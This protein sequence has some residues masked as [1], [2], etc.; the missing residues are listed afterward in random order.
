LLRESG[1]GQDI[2]EVRGGINCKNRIPLTD[3]NTSS[4]VIDSLCDQAKKKDIAVTGLYCDFLSQQD[5]T[6]ANIMGA[7]LKQLVG[8]GGIPNYVREAFQEAKSEFGGRGLRLADLMG[9]LRT[10]ITSLPRGFICIDALDECLPKHLPELLEC[11]RDIARES[12]ST[13]IF[14]T[15]RPHVG[16]VIHRYFTKAVV[17][18]ISP[19]TDDMRNYVE[20]RLDRDAEPEAMSNDLRADIVRVTQENISDMYVGPFGISTMSVMYTYQ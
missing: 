12:P 6:I 7:I 13:R 10:A 11:L 14:L 19:S 18:P 15:G 3:G 16:E 8:R 20:M 1:S 2:S 17:I 9:M 5:Q 4:L